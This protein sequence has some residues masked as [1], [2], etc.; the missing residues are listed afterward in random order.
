MKFVVE[1]DE[2]LQDFYYD[3]KPWTNRDSVVEIKNVYYAESYSKKEK[4][5]KFGDKNYYELHFSNQGGLVMPV[6]IE[7]TYEDGT[8]EIERIPVQIWRLNEDEF[9]KVFVKDK[10]VT[11]VIIDPF[12]ETADVD[13]SNNEWP[14]R[15]VPSKFQ[16][17]KKHQQGKMPNGMQR[18]QGKS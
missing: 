7:W 9:T 6:I 15:E 3:Y 13:R 17:F 12:K 4:K 1:E 16:V 10:V 11:S 8:K 5:K 14:V 18:A 2:K